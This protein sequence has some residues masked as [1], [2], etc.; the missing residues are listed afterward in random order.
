MRNAVRKILSEYEFDIIHADQI[1]M[2]QFVP[3][4][5][6]A[7]GTLYRNFDAHNATWVIISRM[8]ERESVWLRPLLKSELHR[9][10][11]YEGNVVCDFDHTLAVSEIDRIDL[12]EAARVSNSDQELS[13][14]S[15][16]VIPISVDTQVLTPISR[17]PDTKQIL[18]LG[19]LH[20]QPNADGIR[21]FLQFVFPLIQQE[22]PDVR[23]IIVGK[24][25]PKDFLEQARDEPE[26]ILVTG[27]VEDLTP[28]YENSAI[29]VVPLLI[30]SGMRVRILEALARGIPLITTS[31]GLEGIHA[32]QGKEVLVADEPSE[33]AS[34]VIQVLGDLTLQE[35]LSVNGRTLIQERYDWR[36]ALKAMDTIY[37]SARIRNRRISVKMKTKPE[38]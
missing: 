6:E 25:P 10:R 15:I 5:Q 14:T 37:D 12:V 16:S 18:T 20:Y 32:Q 26:S 27:Y 1:T 4:S 3:S 33:F 22:C 29:M 7:N 34:K 21:W 31:I 8:L 30:G 11:K 28:Y 24:N 35:T 19:T 36:I 2:T 17:V 13:S 38:V 23:L 9:I